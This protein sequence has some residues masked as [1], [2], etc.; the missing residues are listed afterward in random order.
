MIQNQAQ[1]QNFSQNL[2]TAKEFLNRQLMIDNIEI[3]NN[4][5]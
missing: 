1:S 5:S 2:L 3:F 4:Y